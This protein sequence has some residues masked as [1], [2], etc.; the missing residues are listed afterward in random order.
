MEMTLKFKKNY[1]YFL[2]IVGLVKTDASN[3]CLQNNYSLNNA[4]I[5][6]SKKIKTKRVLN[7]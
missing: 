3:N 4:I 7:T 5:N 2:S 6:T 1:L